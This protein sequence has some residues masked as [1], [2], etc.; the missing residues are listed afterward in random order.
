MKA[1][2]EAGKDSGLVHTRVTTSANVSDISQTPML[3]HGQE[4][5]VWL[6]ADY[7]GV[8]KREDMQAAV[9]ANG[10]E[11]QWYI[12]KR[13]KGLAKNDAQ[14]NVLFALGNLYMARKK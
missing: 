4:Q 5:D 10:Q 2:I 11:V 13:C 6:D 9:A 14:L 8:E 1:H 3:L 7:A 12:D